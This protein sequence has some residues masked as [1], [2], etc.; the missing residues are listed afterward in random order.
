[1]AHQLSFVNG[2]A[3]LAFLLSEGAC[4]HNYGQGLPDDATE[5]QWLEASNIGNWFIHRKKAYFLNGANPVEVPNV[6][7]LV[8]SDSP[9]V[10]GTVS[11][12]SFHVHQPQDVVKWAFQ[13]VN[14]L[15]FQM[16]TMGVL[17]Q[18]K[19]IWVQ[20]NIKQ[21]VA[22]GGNDYVDGK[23][24][25]CVPNTGKESTIVNYS[26]TRVVCN[27]TLRAATQSGKMLLKLSHLKKFK[28]DEI[29][30]ALGLFDL[31][32]WAKGA[33]QMTR[34]KLTETQA[35]DYFGKIFKV[36]YSDVT[37]GSIILDEVATHTIQNHADVIN[38][39]RS[40]VD[41][42]VATTEAAKATW[43][44][45]S[46]EEQRNAIAMAHKNAGKVFELFNGAGIG[47]QM[48]SA[49]GTLWGALNA[50]TEFADHKR[51]A[52]TAE[53][54]FDSAYWGPWADVKDLAYQEAVKMM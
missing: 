17:F 23:F 9:V 47:S 32:D 50:V 24:L 44:V 12:D 53:N 46:I 18:G 21:R 14:D 22:I 54:R 29:N 28:A 40:I 36:D 13:L 42:I 49:K 11:A 51:R 8:R 5:D 10:L 39:S 38:P 19:K 33:E 45:P 6:I 27:N 2:I 41:D 34:V 52:H 48:D 3:E 20:A 43:T 25:I 4:W 1:M 26:A 7:H 30:Q 16:S 37:T 31:Q 15:G 35:L